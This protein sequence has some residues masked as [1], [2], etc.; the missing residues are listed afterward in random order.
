MGK[1]KI[2]FKKKKKRERNSK[3]EEADRDYNQL[4]RA[5]R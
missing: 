5:A 1:A 4:R 3:Q 2:I